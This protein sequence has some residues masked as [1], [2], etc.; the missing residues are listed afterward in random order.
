MS[1]TFDAMSK[2]VKEVMYGKWI[3]GADGRW[4][5]LPVPSPT[6]L[7]AVLDE[8][9]ALQADCGRI[10]RLIRIIWVPLLNRHGPAEYLSGT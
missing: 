2:R 7:E 8:S 5:W 6:P 3:S 9:G 1:A 4:W 10:D